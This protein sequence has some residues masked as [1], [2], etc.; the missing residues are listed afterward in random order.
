MALF[1]EDEEMAIIDSIEVSLISLAVMW[2]GR[3]N[4]K[5]LFP[6]REWWLWERF[7]EGV[8]VLMVKLAGRFY[9]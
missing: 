7:R 1:R 6:G 9:D 5:I 4:V 2:G 3:K 8:K